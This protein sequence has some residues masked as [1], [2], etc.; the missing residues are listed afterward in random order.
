MV[1]VVVMVEGGANIPHTKKSFL[2]RDYCDEVIGYCAD[3]LQW[4]L[5]FRF[6]YC[7]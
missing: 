7:S 5:I 3:A 4:T 2:G 1:V 6:V